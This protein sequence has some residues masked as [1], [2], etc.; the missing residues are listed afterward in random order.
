M[1]IA[2]QLKEAGQ[3]A[4][5]EITEALKKYSER[6]GLLVRDVVL[7]RSSESKTLFDYI[8]TS[9]RVQF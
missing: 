4:E 3:E 9:I 2:E 5:G 8:G 7:M 1:T 6:T